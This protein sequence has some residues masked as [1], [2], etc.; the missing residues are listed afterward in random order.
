MRNVRI[1]DLARELNRDNKEVLAICDRLGITYKSHSSTITEEE[2]DAIKRNMKS[3]PATMTKTTT[4]KPAAKVPEIVTKPG[5]SKQQILQVYRPPAP[6]VIKP[7]TSDEVIAAVLVPTPLEPIAVTEAVA[8]VVTTPILEL[9]KPTVPIIESVIES[10]PVVVPVAPIAVEPVAVIAIEPVPIAVIAAQ[11]VTEAPPALM[12]KVVLPPAA[13]VVPATVAAVIAP[14]QQPAK[15]KKGRGRDEDEETADEEGQDKKQRKAAPT[16]GAADPVVQRATAKVTTAPSRS[17]AAPTLRRGPNK[18]IL[19]GTQSSSPTISRS[20]NSNNSTEVAVPKI[21]TLGSGTIAIQDLAALMH[22]SPTE[23][24]KALFMKGKMVT[25][26]QTLEQATAEM[27]AT[28]LGFEVQQ[29]QNVV[30]AA[31]KTEMLDIDDLDNLQSRPPVVTIMGHVDHG[32]TSLLDAIRTTKVA[33]GEAGGITQRIGAYVVPVNNRQVAFLDTPGHAAFTAMRARGAKVTDIAVLVVA[34]DDGVMPQT[35]EAISHA[36]A[37]GVPIV[38]AIN[39]MDRPDAN[40]DRVKQELAEFNL[41]PEEWGGETIMVPVSAREQTNLDLL[42]EMLLLQADLLD[43]QANPNRA[44]KGTVIEA[45]L[46]KNRGPVATVLVQNGTLHIG[47]VFVVGPIFGRVRAM[48]DDQGRAILHATPSVPVEVSGFAQVPMAGEELEVYLDEREARRI[49]ESRAIAFRDNRLSHQLSTRK[50][51]LGSLSVKAQEGELKELNL[52]IKADVQGSIEALL[53][54]LEKLPQTKVQLRILLSAAGEVTEADIDLALASNAVIVAFS[55][56]VLTNARSLA[57]QV[58]VDIR[59]YDVIYKLLEDVED[60]MAGLL[61]PELIEE[62]LGVAE[63]RM[64]IPVGKLGRIAGCYVQEGK[65]VRNCLI[66][67]RR[68][69]EVVFEGHIDSLKRFKEDARE[70]LPGFECGIGSGQFNAWENG[71]LIEAYRMVTRKR[72][73]T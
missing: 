14:G 69:K 39:K 51:S 73:L 19:A 22:V 36:Q 31:H 54:S 46:D 70:V 23:I 27:V 41:V 43:L 67:V 65:V 15:A 71:D 5:T 47:D 58:G 68:A 24:I 38:V 35:K 26:N 62:P 66:R 42:L 1:Y 45:H 13:V 61:A 21:L 44:A 20:R 28:E 49:A 34:A 16:K 57:E 30:A 12:P 52:I 56:T 33:Q 7:A 32:K 59:E 48:F 37:A 8:P 53:G 6:A 25:I 40:P 18:P 4:H 55:T 29:D 17:T 11:V 72:S 10:L 2:A 60:A 9:V 63:V 64:V 3:R 50:V